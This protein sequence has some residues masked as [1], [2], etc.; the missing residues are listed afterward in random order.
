MKHPLFFIHF[1]KRNLISGD[2]GYGWVGVIDRQWWL[3]LSIPVI[4]RW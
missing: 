2:Y 3:E 1:G 4:G